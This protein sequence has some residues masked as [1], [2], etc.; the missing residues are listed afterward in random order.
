MANTSFNSNVCAKNR[1]TLILIV[2]IFSELSLYRKF[3]WVQW[4]LLFLEIT[5]LNV[6]NHLIKMLIFIL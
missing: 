5:A 4:F 1:Y 3:S 6:F 2:D